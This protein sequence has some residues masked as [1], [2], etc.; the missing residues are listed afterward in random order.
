MYRMDFNP[1]LKT[2]N[3]DLTLAWTRCLWWLDIGYNG[4]FSAVCRTRKRYVHVRGTVKFLQVWP[5]NNMIISLK[6]FF[7]ILQSLKSLQDAGSRRKLKDIET[8]WRIPNV[9]EGSLCITKD[10][11]RTLDCLGSLMTAKVLN[12]SSISLKHLWLTDWLNEWQGQ[13]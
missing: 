9:L 6:Q 3:T 5:N 4:L 13:I 7:K 11:C 8:S 10:F 12:G 2:P 1:R